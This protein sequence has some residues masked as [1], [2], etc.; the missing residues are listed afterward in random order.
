MRRRPTLFMGCRKKKKYVCAARSY[1]TLSLRSRGRQKKKTNYPVPVSAQ[2]PE[3]KPTLFLNPHVG[4]ATTGSELLV[5][6][7]GK[8]SVLA[9]GL[10]KLCY[11]YICSCNLLREQDKDKT[12]K[13]K[14]PKKHCSAGKDVFPP[15]EAP[16]SQPCIQTFW[17]RN[18][19][20]LNFLYLFI[21]SYGGKWLFLAV[22]DSRNKQ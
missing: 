19:T 12:Q 10:T 18:R 3:P 5:W 8:G 15:K 16:L 1:L 13:Q 7:T 20:A 17:N 2:L 11:N 6:A 22:K 21:K 9:P 4:S 14:N